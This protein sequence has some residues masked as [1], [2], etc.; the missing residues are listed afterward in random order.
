[1]RLPIGGPTYTLPSI[2]IN[3]QACLNMYPVSAGPTGDPEQGFALIPTVG[4][5]SL[6]DTSTGVIRGMINVDDVIYVVSGNT[7]YKLTINDYT[8][9]ATTTSV[10]TLSSSTGLVSMERNTTQILI[11]DGSSTGYITTIATGTTAA[12]ADADFT[13]GSSAVFMD[14][15][16]IANT[17][18]ASTLQA[19]AISDGTSWSALDFTTAE[20]KPDKVVGLAVD[21]RELWIFGERTIEMWYDAAN[22]TGFPFSRRDGAFIDLGC[23]AARSI[24]NFDNSL[25]WLDHRGYIVRAEG[26]A[27]KVIS[28]EPVHAAIQSY[29]VISDA[30]AWSHADRGHLFYCITFPS[31]NKTW[32]YDATTDMWHERGD[33]DEEENL[34]ED[35]IS[36]CVRYKNLYLAG[37]TAT[38]L[39]Y[40]LKHDVYTYNGDPIRRLRR[41]GHQRLEHSRIDISSVRLVA[42]TGHALATGTGSDT[43]LMFRYSNDKGYTWSNELTTSFGQ[44]G[45]YNDD[46][47]FNR[48]GTARNWLFEFVIVEPISFALL[49]LTLE[50]SPGGQ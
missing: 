42:Q 9:T 11:V 40:V 29:T 49:D 13:G 48:L 34:Q 21:K 36:C 44:I 12:I 25:V 6:V 2:D 4:R 32:C 3:N 8:Q 45:E 24:L 38:S 27:P 14:S 19:S 22:P 35:D 47:R 26:Y 31:A 28:T 33:L 20:G 39:V 10:G 50:V 46:I 17:P 18:N 5:N 37:S 43:Q 23:A 16:F 30:F 1:M 15:Y 41:L 7:V